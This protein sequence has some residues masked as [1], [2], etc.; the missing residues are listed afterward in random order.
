[1]KF[2]G[3]WPCLSLGLHFPSQLDFTKYSMMALSTLSLHLHPPSLSVCCV[4]SRSVM[5]NSL[6]PHGQTCQ[7]PL[8]TGIL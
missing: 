2:L 7:V 5:S 1:M 3:Q 8:S 4:L 6:Q